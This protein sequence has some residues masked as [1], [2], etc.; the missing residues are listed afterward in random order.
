MEHKMLEKVDSPRSKTRKLLRH[1]VVN[2]N[3]TKQVMLHHVL[4]KELHEKYKKNKD[5]RD[6]QKLRRIVAGNI[7]KKYKM[8]KRLSSELRVNEHRLGKKDLGKSLKYE[9]RNR[10]DQVSDDTK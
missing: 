10:S 4:L 1:C 5:H 8:V 3:V 7:V 6:K 2:E 9:R